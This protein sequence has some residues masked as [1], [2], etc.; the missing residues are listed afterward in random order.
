MFSGV[1]FCLSPSFRASLA[2]SLLLGACKS[3]ML[4]LHPA[5]DRH[6]DKLGLVGNRRH[7]DRGQA[8]WLFQGSQSHLLYLP[9]GG[10]L[11]R[12]QSKPV[13]N[14]VL[15]LEPH[16][17]G[18]QT[19]ITAPGRAAYIRDSTW[20]ANHLAEARVQREIP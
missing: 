20:W 19:P 8:F 11:A 6:G 18:Q 16:A 3:P 7:R 12:A 4:V 9:V 1:T 10:E 14:L 5:Y 2:C 13:H 17:R 15:P